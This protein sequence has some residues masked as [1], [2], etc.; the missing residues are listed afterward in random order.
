MIAI[1][2]VKSSSFL[3]SICWMRFFHKVKNQ[4]KARACCLRMYEFTG[5]Q[6]FLHP[7][8]SNIPF[9]IL[10]IK[11]EIVSS[12]LRVFSWLMTK[13]CTEIIKLVLFNF[14]FKFNLNI[15]GSARVWWW[16]P[17]HYKILFS[18]EEKLE[19][20]ADWKKHVGEGSV[21]TF[22]LKKRVEKTVMF[23]S[24]LSGKEWWKVNA[25]HPG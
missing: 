15:S 19:I 4:E 21:G 13:I 1:L 6:C 25:K 14:L 17:A 3:F 7:W 22:R 8:D 2:P 11:C 5:C 23:L 24:C 10:W 9:L 20:L 16:N 18:G 12:L